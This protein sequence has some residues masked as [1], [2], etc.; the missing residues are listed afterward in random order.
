VKQEPRVKREPRLKQEPQAN[1]NLKR[2]RTSS[3]QEPQVEQDSLI[4]EGT[5][6]RMTR[7]QARSSSLLSRQV[8]IKEEEDNCAKAALF[9]L[10]TSTEIPYVKQEETKTENITPSTLAAAGNNCKCSYYGH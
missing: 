1:K 6:R 4:K 2:T 5:T 10:S 8:A 3:E 9:E 7:S